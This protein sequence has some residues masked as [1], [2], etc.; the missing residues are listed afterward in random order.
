MHTHVRRWGN[1]LALRIPKILAKE[2]GIVEGSLVEIELD[3]DTLSVT[4]VPA[5]RYT[6]AGLLAEVTPDN[7]HGEVKT[8]HAVGRE[9]W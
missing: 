6:L 3:G 2:A 9:D 4:A 5:K 7:V 1:S 8:G